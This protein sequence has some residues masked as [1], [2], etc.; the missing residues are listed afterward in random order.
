MATSMGSKCV[1]FAEKEFHEDKELKIPALGIKC[2]GFSFLGV[3]SE[4][5]ARACDEVLSAIEEYESTA[6]VQVIPKDIL[7]AKYMAH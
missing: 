4:E 2:E 3:S 7:L 1:E 6:T 5:Y